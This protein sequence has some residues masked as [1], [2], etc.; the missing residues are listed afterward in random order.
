MLRA[1]WSEREALAFPLL[2]LPIML[3]ED[4]NRQ[5]DHT[6]GAFFRNPLLPHCGWHRLPADL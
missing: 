5:G 1:Q 4:M 3:T 6:F 2:R